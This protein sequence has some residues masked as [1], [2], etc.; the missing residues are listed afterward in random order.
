M[1]VFEQLCYDLGP[2][3]ALELWDE[4]QKHNIPTQQDVA[5]KAFDAMRDAF[6]EAAVAL[7][8]LATEIRSLKPKQLK[9]INDAAE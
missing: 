5:T 2:E 3:R 9:E 7:E 1:G 6:E 8:S 4:I